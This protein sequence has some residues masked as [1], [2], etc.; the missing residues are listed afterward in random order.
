MKGVKLQPFYTDIIPEIVIEVD[1]KADIA[2]EPNYYL[3][4]TKHLIKKGVRRVI[5]VFTSTEQVMIAENGKAW[6]TEDWSK[7]VKIEDNCRINIKKMMDDF[8][9]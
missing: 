6:I 4:K 7:S 8:E 9:E 1:T 2:H 5:W 3:D